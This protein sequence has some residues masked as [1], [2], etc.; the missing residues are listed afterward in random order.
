[1]PC[2][3]YNY[4]KYRCYI[5]KSN[6]K[7]IQ[8]EKNIIFNMLK[9]SSAL[10]LIINMFQAYGDEEGFCY[11]KDIF[12]L[13][14]GDFFSYSHISIAKG[15]NGKFISYD[16]S[17]LDDSKQVTK[18]EELQATHYPANQQIPTFWYK[19]KLSDNGK[20]S[21]DTTYGAKAIFQNIPL[22][23]GFGT[24]LIDG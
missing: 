8:I 24:L 19:I 9:L 21:G 18:D 7:V 13:L 16:P 10:Y 15:A 5:K 17:K 23:G 3:K 14:N 2:L 6:N 1:M 4:G 22:E 20:W 12:Q 11:P